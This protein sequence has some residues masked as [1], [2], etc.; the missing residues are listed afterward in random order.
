MLI[1]LIVENFARNSEVQA[2]FEQMGMNMEELGFSVS[3]R[4]L[5]DIHFATDVQYDPAP[6]MSR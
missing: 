5:P 2:A 6:K 3:L 4:A 1:F